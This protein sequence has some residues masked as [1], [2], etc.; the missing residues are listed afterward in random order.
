MKISERYDLYL[1]LSLFAVA[2][3]NKS[4]IH[5]NAR[6]PCFSL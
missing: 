5:S 4:V 6:K 2:K 1:L 3:R